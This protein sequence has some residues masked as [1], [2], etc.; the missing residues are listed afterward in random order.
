MVLCLGND[1]S[2]T[3]WPKM[4]VHLGS[5]Q[6]RVHARAHLPQALHP[7]Q[8]SFGMG[9]RAYHLMPLHLA[10]PCFRGGGGSPHELICPGPAPSSDWLCFWAQGKLTCAETHCHLGIGAAVGLC[11]SLFAPAPHQSQFEEAGGWGE[12]GMNLQRG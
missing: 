2:T 12:P 1:S 8:A 11:T 10:L 6:G 4:V 7:P 5:R 9:S 3:W